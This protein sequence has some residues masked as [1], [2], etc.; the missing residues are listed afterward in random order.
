MPKRKKSS[1]LMGELSKKK[2]AK[3]NASTSVRVSIDADMRTGVD[4]E[5]Q[6]VVSSSGENTLL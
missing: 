6:Q 2:Y 3:S 1:L 4:A 5:S